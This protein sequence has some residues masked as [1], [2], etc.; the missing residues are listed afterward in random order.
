MNVWTKEDLCKLT[1]VNWADWQVRILNTMLRAH[2]EGKKLYISYP[3]QGKRMIIQTYD[4]ITA[5]ENK[6][7]ILRGR[8]NGHV[9]FDE[10]ITEG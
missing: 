9:I 2:R 6:K 10:F 4:M 1:G 7:D 8:G 3:R 5:A